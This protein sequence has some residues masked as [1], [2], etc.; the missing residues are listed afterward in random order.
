[1]QVGIRVKYNKRD[2]SILEKYYNEIAPRKMAIAANR[3]RN[4]MMNSIKRRSYSSRGKKPAPSPAGTPPHSISEGM[5]GT[6]K[7][8]KAKKFYPMRVIKYEKFSS[9]WPYIYMVG[10]APFSSRG[11]MTMKAPRIHETGGT[12]SRSKW[13]YEG[14]PHGKRRK[15][16]KLQKE[17]YKKK[18]RQGFA[19]AS[20]PDTDILD[21]LKIKK[22]TRT[23]N[24]PSRPYVKPSAIKAAD[25]LPGLFK[26][27]VKLH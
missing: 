13:G 15:A 25:E 4:R 26:F 12:I 22:K 10:V 21:K 5:S 6:T 8:G 2:I 14:K 3:A 19:N 9:K 17:A 16:S 24:Y 11:R 7:S 1:M 27:V 18:M 23:Y 20:N